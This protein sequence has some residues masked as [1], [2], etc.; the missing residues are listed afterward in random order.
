M[1]F[2]QFEPPKMSGQLQC[3]RAPTR[4]HQDQ[5]RLRPRPPRLPL[6]VPQ[7]LQTV[8][9]GVEQWGHS[10]VG[11]FWPSDPGERSTFVG[12]LRPVTHMFA[13]VGS[14]SSTFPSMTF[15]FLTCFSKL[16]WSLQLI[17]SIRHG[18]QEKQESD[19]ESCAESVS[20]GRDF[21]SRWRMR[22]VRVAVGGS[23][24]ERSGVQFH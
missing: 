7:A 4:R 24:C 16:R 12:I 10:H 18:K 5:L 22:G 21:R 19:A 23:V 8:R 1:A 14:L 17:S 13:S 20:S 9:S 15:S 2:P 11:S 3:R 6:R